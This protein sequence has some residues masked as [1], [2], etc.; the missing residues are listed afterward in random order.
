M[1]GHVVTLTGPSGSGKTSIAKLLQERHPEEFSEVVSFTTRAMRPG[2]QEGREYYFITPERFREMEENGE[3]L[4]TV[5]FDGRNYGS[6]YAEADAKREGRLASF[7]IVEPHGVDQWVENYDAPFLHVFLE[8]PSEEE[9]RRRMLGQGRSEE[10]VNQRLAHDADVF[11]VD[12]ACYHLVVTNDD[13][14][15]A[16]RTVRDFVR[17]RSSQP[18]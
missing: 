15:Q 7:V 14:E 2:E 1:R 17:S 9:L 5:H 3:F 11:N 18:T 10:S 16:C 6:A 8:P 13:L 4:E 12:K